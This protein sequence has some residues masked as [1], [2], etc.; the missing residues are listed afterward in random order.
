MGGEKGAKQERGIINMGGIPKIGNEGTRRKRKGRQVLNFKKA[1]PR[2][3]LIRSPWNLGY[4]LSPLGV[5]IG[6]RT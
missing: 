1:K 2:R 3:Q 6:A 4:G 5:G